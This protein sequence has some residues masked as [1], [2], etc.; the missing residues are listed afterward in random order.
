MHR[1]NDRNSGIDHDVD[2]GSNGNSD[3]GGDDIFMII[4]ALLESEGVRYIH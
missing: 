4:V 1:P 2:D 3:A